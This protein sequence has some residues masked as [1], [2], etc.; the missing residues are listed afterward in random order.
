MGQEWLL[1]LP[2][3]EFLH[4]KFLLAGDSLFRQ[5]DCLEPMKHPHYWGSFTFSHLYWRTHI[6]SLMQHKAART[7]THDPMT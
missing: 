1:L 5:Q 4:W 6:S 2:C 7:D 3:P